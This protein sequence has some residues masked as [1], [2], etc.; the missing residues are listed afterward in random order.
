MINIRDKKGC[1]TIKL[2]VGYNAIKVLKKHSSPINKE[3]S[4]KISQNLSKVFTKCS[5]TE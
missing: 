5:E 1:I 3:I 4:Q 2:L